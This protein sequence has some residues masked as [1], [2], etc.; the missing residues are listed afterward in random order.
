MK[1]L[2]LVL[3]A[4]VAS[5]GAQAQGNRIN[6]VRHDAPELAY[7]GDYTIGVRTIEVTDKH[8]VD[9]LN[10]AAGGETAYYDRSLVVEVWYP[11]LLASNQQPGGRFAIN[12]CIFRSGDE[13]R[14][15]DDHSYRLGTEWQ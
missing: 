9:I 3:L 14:F 12:G 10:T 4:I 15:G 5:S 8:R 13:G 7:F 1:K 11:A 2:L 6:I